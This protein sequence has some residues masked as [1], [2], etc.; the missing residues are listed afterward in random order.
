[1]P[2]VKQALRSSKNYGIPV[3]RKADT[4]EAQNRER[5]GTT[6]EPRGSRNAVAWVQT[7][8]Y[9]DL[10]ED[11]QIRPGTE[12]GYTSG[13]GN[14]EEEK[15]GTLTVEGLQTRTEIQFARTRAATEDCRARQTAKGRASQRVGLATKGTVLLKA[16]V[17]H[18][19]MKGHVAKGLYLTLPFS[20]TRANGNMLWASDVI[21]TVLGVTSKYKK[22]QVKLIT[23]IYLT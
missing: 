9:G 21:F 6:T 16:E 15:S 13:T 1:M 18:D 4:S 14:V 19:V 8:S 12:P 20:C 3:F 17:T 7:V 11:T 2:G 22:K 10:C 23:I 5:K